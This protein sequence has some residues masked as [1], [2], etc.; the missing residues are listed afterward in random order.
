[1]HAGARCLATAAGGFLLASAAA[2]VD[3]EPGDIVA[4]DNRLGST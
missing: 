3:L 2:A 1:M 4:I